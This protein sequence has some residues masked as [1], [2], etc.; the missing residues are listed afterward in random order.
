MQSDG[1]DESSESD[2]SDRD[3]YSDECQVFKDSYEGYEPPCGVTGLVDKVSADIAPREFYERYI[4]LRRPV[5]IRGL[6]TDT[7]WKGN[8]WTNNYLIE[9]AGKAKLLVEDR[10]N[11]S[12]S[13]YLSFG[14]TAPKIEMLYGDFLST[15]SGGESRYYITTQDP[16]KSVDK[17]DDFGL[18][19]TVYSEPLLSLVGE[20]PVQPQLL[21]NLIPH[22]LSLWQGLAGREQRSSSGLHHD[23]HDNLYVLI[24]G[25]KRFRL[26]PPSALPSL[27]VVGT[28]IT[29]HRNGLIVYK[30]SDIH[31]YR[32]TVGADGA[33]LVV[34]ARQKRYNAERDLL[35]AENRLASL[36][37]VYGS[38]DEKIEAAE[39]LVDECE[40][41]LEDALQELLRYTELLILSAIRK[42][43]IFLVI[44]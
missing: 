39:R 24:R 12:G 19:K 44:V 21:G 9:K 37:S 31:P 18:V 15:L 34:V 30:S 1:V 8:G 5:I 40:Q 33:P 42:I 16:E 14:T 6:L 32:I 25:R 43:L 7:E 2:W 41:R 22:Q 13:G 35:A 36:R 4:R 10:K 38:S 29:I 11:P 27:K 20:F 3:D 26:F 23:F 28:P 17:C